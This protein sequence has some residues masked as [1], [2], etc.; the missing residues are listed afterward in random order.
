M[1]LYS[2]HHS[3]KASLI[4]Q[5]K[6]SLGLTLI[7]VMV[8]LLIFS[9]TA[10]AVM[11]AATEHLRGVSM[12]EEMTFATYVANNRMTQ[13]SLEEK[14]PLQ[15]TSKGSE[16]LG[17]RTWYWQQKAIKTQEADML[18]VEI[19]VSL[20]QAGDN[21]VTTISTFI[22]NPNIT[23]SSQGSNNGNK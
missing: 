5:L 8:A 20:D 2:G 10:T 16:E 17:G 6:F 14:W 12:L 4:K 1:R 11:K 9:V 21:V 23:G 13:V 15:S 7:E 18:S 3:A 22:A 19:S